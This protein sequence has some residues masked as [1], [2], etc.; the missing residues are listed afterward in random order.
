[1]AE[2]VASILWLIV[3]VVLVY[4]GKAAVWCVSVGCWRSESL[5]G[6]EGRIYAAAGGL[7]FVRDGQ[8]VVTPT[9]QLFAGLAFCA[10]LIVAVIFYVAKV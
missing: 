2:F 9:G 7:S 6:E 4:A 8:R 3:E 1:M 10:L 5:G